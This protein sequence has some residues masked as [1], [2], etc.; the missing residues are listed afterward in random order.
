MKPLQI[1]LI[2]ALLG[3]GASLDAQTTITA[4]AAPGTL[5]LIP[6]VPTCFGN[7]STSASACGNTVTFNFT[8]FQISS[9]PSSGQMPAPGSVAFGGPGSSA[10][11]AFY[12]TLSYSPANEHQQLLFSAPITTFQFSCSGPFGAGEVFSVQVYNGA[13]QVGNHTFNVPGQGVNLTYYIGGAP[14]DRV[15]F[16]EINAISADDELFG[17]FFVDGPGCPLPVEMISA[18]ARFEHG[19]AVHVEWETH[20]ESALNHFAVER[21]RDGHIWTEL[22]RRA[23]R[24]APGPNFYQYEDRDP[25][26][27]ANY[28]RIAVTGQNG[29]QEFSPVLQ[30][31]VE[32]APN[33]TVYLL[34]NPARE[35]TVLELNGMPG[36]KMVKISTLLGRVVDQFSVESSRGELD[37]NGYP[38]GIYLIQVIHAGTVRNR[39]L[40]V[41]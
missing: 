21:S 36:R 6:F 31:A 39:R 29:E 16:T 40:I 20:G 19:H 7:G 35:T 25:R 33:P 10:S 4:G 5:T 27:G 8:S 24:N 3:L 9:C 14:F 22:G 26:V 1:T 12:H 2:V 41:E 17:D 18:E 28:Y 37:L 30:V 15:Q 11:F 32:R 38:A 23:A 13:T 34:P